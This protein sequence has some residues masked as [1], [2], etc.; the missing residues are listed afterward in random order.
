MLGQAKSP[1]GVKV[2]AGKTGTT[3]KAGNCLILLSTN[4]KNEEFVSVILNANSSSQLYSEM[5]HL[6]SY[7]K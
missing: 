3:N 2:I 6:L 1:D 4:S 5:T 7:I